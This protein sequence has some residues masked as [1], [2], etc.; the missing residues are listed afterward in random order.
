MS[1]PARD[2]SPAPDAR[3]GDDF[4][5]IFATPLVIRDWPDSDTLNT[6][7]AGLI[8]AAQMAVPGVGK[9]NVGGWHSP[10]DF[11]LGEVPALATLRERIRTVVI[12]LTR[13]L[14]APGAYHFK[15]DGWANILRAGDYNGPHNHPNATWSGVYY[16]TGVPEPA[17]RQPNAVPPLAGKIEFFDPRPA[18]GMVYAAE[19]ML[20]RRCLFTPRPGCML[21]FPSWLQHMVHPHDGAGERHSIAFNVTVG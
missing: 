19:S 9:S 10:P 4:S 3:G 17:D 11:I 2:N 7:L 13:R 15:I 1:T 6:E 21:V 5:M 14:M 20:Q 16:L 8:A 18:A 12:E